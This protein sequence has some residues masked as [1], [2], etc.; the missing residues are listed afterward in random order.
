MLPLRYSPRRWQ[1]SVRRP[2]LPLPPL[3]RNHDARA[4]SSRLVRGDTVY[5]GGELCIQIALLRWTVVDE[6]AMRRSRGGRIDRGARGAGAL[7]V[8]SR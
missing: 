3:P 5:R 8:A 6:D 4:Y 7:V 1:Q 2:R